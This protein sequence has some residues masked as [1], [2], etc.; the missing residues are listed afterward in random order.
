MTRRAA[1]PPRTFAERLRLAQ[2]ESGLTTEGL[3][4][5]I[6][7]GVRVVQRWRS[8][9]G[10]PSGANLVALSAALDR[11][12]SWFYSEPDAPVDTSRAA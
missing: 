1:N 4:R 3:A 5:Q 10:M 6:G 2:A 9:N 7:V 11:D 8:G 12:A